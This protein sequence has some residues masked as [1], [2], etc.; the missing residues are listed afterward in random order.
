MSNRTKIAAGIALTIALAG[1][2]VIAV[3]C[4]TSWGNEQI[5]Q[6][7]VDA[8]SHKDVRVK[9]GRVGDF[10]LFSPF[11]VVWATVED[12][13][14]VGPDDSELA[15]V[16]EFTAALDVGALLTRTVHLRE[17]NAQGVE[18]P[19]D[20]RTGYPRVGAPG[21]ARRKAFEPRAMDV[22]FD[23]VSLGLYLVDQTEEGKQIVGRIHSELAG[24]VPSDEPGVRLTIKQAKGMISRPEAIE[25]LSAS[26]DV[27]TSATKV[28]DISFSAITHGAAITG[29]LAYVPS[30]PEH[31]IQPNIAN[32]RDAGM[33]NN[34]PMDALNGMGLPMDALKN[35]KPPQP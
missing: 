34:N 6:Y 13:R 31:P 1:S 9:I 23:N 28:A 29:S 22:Q 3:F 2:V 25:L 27:D 15:A 19:V 4:Y 21:G 26:G 18:I 12:V 10:K 17:V 30:D 7:L 20:R 16:G 8:V 11:G 32:V 14:V 35:F 24:T 5:R 33:L